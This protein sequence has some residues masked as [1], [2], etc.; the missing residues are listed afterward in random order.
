MDHGRSGSTGHLVRMAIWIGAALAL[1][2]LLWYAVDVFL[3]AFAGALL[4]IFLRG[5]ADALARWTALSAGLALAAVGIVLTLAI[6]GVGWLL[7]PHVADQASALS[8]SLPRSVERLN[9]TVSR[10]APGRQ[11]L[12]EMPQ[13]AELLPDRSDIFSRVTGVFSTTLGVLAN[14]V[15]V[16]FLGLYLAVEPST[17]RDG[18]LRLVPPARRQRACEV[19]SAVVSTLRWWLIGKVASMMVIG[20]LT[21]VGLLFLD[22]PLALTLALLAALLTFIPNVGPIIAAV[23]AVLL[24]LLQG[25]VVAGAVIALYVAIQ[26]VESYVLTPLVQRRTVSLPP[27]LTITAQVLLGVLLGGLGL[28][29]ATPLTAAALVLVKMLYVEDVLGDRPGAPPS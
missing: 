9:Q 10:Y 24:G 29:L 2:A 23:P 27:G 13:P 19:L 5:L 7:A 26:T 3:L 8:E 12:Q 17:Y 14:V 20:V 6:L 15:I 11:V 16:L 22:V 4:A 1:V 25:L 21:Y 18:V 28:A